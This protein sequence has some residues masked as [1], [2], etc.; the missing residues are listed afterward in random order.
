MRL[1]LTGASG[2][3]GGYLLRELARTEWPV[4]AWTGSHTGR[5]YGA[6]LEPVDLADRDHVVRAFREARPT[7]VIHAA[8]LAS[9]AECHRSPERARRV[10][11]EGSG[12]LARLAAEAGARLVYVSTDLVFDGRRGNYRED[13]PISPLSIYGTTKAAGEEAVLAVPRNAVVRVTLLFGPTLTG[14]PSFFDDQLAALRSRRP[15]RLFRD[16]WRTPLSLAVA[17]PALL[18]VCRADFTGLLHLG[19]PERMTRLEMGRRLAAYLR[20]DD[21]VFVPSGQGDAP[22]GEPRPRDVSLDSSR[23]RQLFPKDPW[24]TF[25][26][27]LK[28]LGLP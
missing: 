28:E 16:E 21:R 26:Q 14:R 10:N 4:V 23:W 12:T 27:A 7:A 6:E 1:L 24:P 9:V 3:L 18:A 5:S 17:A 19:G 2:R 20:S 11:A 8:A 15:I 25:E 22:V 13:D